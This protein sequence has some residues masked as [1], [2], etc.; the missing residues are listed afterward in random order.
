MKKIV[1][2]GYNWAGCKALD[3]LLRDKNQV[4]VFTH[5]NPYYVNS[6]IELCKKRKVPFS[7][8]RIRFDILPFVPDVIASI[9]YRFVI[10]REVI[11]ACGGKIFNLHPSL[12]PR[13]RGC[14]SLTWAMINGEKTAGFT[15]HY[16]TENVDGGKIILQ[17]TVAI[18][19]WDTQ[20][21]LYN[22]VMFEGM[23]HFTEV[24]QMVYRG[25]SGSEQKKG[26]R[27]YY[28]RGCPFDG[29][30]D[31]QWSDEMIERFI[32]AM[33]FPPLP[34]AKYNDEFVKS[35]QDYLLLRDK[36]NK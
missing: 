12:L 7:T 26:S 16:I 33:I 14:S 19:D 28:K 3:L 29:K 11:D 25:D 27:S 15:F 1:L 2:C 9:Y 30:I 4:F 32:R 34:L 13:Y 8:E 21:T 5:E 6:L 10:S 35:F 18:E 24:L 36:I 23:K 31:D 20:M 17:K 22:R